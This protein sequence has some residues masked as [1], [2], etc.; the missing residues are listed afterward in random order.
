MF[1][2]G[3]RSYPIASTFLIKIQLITYVA[4]SK[5]TRYA[6]VA[7]CALNATPSSSSQHD[8]IM[9]FQFMW[10]VRIVHKLED[11]R[12][13]MYRFARRVKELP[14]LQRLKHEPMD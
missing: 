2:C 9:A 3:D 13:S 6:N 7:V 1:L 14:E 10:T 11:G 5:T 8:E 4:I 12:V